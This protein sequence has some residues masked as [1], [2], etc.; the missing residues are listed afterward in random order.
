MSKKD[1]ENRS[2]IEEDNHERLIKEMISK[3]IIKKIER[4][5]ERN[6]NEVIKTLK[7]IIDEDRY[8]K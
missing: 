1:L 4:R 6:D 7:T 2:R 5:I 8:K 3:E